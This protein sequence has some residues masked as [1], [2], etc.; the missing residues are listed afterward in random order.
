[1]RVI[2]PVNR[3]CALPKLA[4]WKGTTSNCEES[5]RSRSTTRCSSRRVAPVCWPEAA[6]TMGSITT[7]RFMSVA[8]NV[9]KNAGSFCI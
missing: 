9:A 4:T 8:S 7:P 1:M 6:S 2:V 3:Y 5:L